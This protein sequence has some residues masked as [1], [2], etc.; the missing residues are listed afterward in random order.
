MS[1]GAARLPFEGGMTPERIGL[2]AA[3]GAATLFGSGGVIIKLAYQS[4][5]DPVTLLSTRAFL[6]VLL[7]WALT[8]LQ[9]V[10]QLRLP[11]GDLVRSAGLGVFY[12]LPSLLFFLAL[13]RIEA[14]LVAVLLY[15]FP[16]WTALL[17]RLLYAESISRVRLASLI[18]TFVGITLVVRL[19]D[20]DPQATD[21][22]GVLA[23][24]LQGLGI[25]AFTVLLQP[26]T[27]RQ[28][29]L[30]VNSWVF[31]AAA[32]VAAGIRSPLVILELAPRL[33]ALILLMALL[34]SVLPMYLWLTGVRYLGASR[35]GIIATI[36]PG[37]TMT[38]AFLLLGERLEPLQ[39]L[40]VGAVLGGILLLRV[41]RA[42]PAV[43]LE[44]PEGVSPLRQ[45]A[46]VAR[47]GGDEKASAKPPEPA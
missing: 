7:I 17:T 18:V 2:L 46:P 10:R 11:R 41:E 25:A 32:V 23:A 8:A 37:V 26:L 12:V 47:A 13:E 24:L 31:L 9:D 45:E 15:T 4:G 35:T 30:G 39:L 27:R 6:A 3:L 43:S 19:Y 42:A 1:R 29:T 5:V 34:G 36:E 40:G 22:L 38:L 44:A 20:W 21:P 28:P 14:S 16:A 33:Q